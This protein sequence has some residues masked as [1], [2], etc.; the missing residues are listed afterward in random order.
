MLL[1][2]CKKNNCLTS[3]S[4]PSHFIF[5]VTTLPGRQED[6]CT[7]QIKKFPLPLL[8]LSPLCHFLSLP[9]FKPMSFFSPC[10]HFHLPFLFLLSSPPICSHLSA[11]QFPSLCFHLN[12]SLFPLPLFHI[13]HFVPHLL[14]PYCSS[15]T[16]PLPISLLLSFSFSITLLLLPLPFYSTIYHHPSLPL[17]I[18][19][20]ILSFPV[21]FL[22]IFHILAFLTYF[23]LSPIFYP[24]LFQFWGLFE[25]Q[26]TCWPDVPSLENKVCISSLPFFSPF[27][28][29]HPP[30]L[31]SPCLSQI[32]YHYWCPWSFPFLFPDAM[33]GMERQFKERGKAGRGI[34]KVEAENRQW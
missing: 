18:P 30:K 29:F 24:F 22:L 34:G 1:N 13:S 10:W 32:L 16:S 28:I 9:F 25:H 21:S 23:L 7:T 15:P 26:L 2:L 19:F 33:E 8:Y 12:P 3:I 20:C 11:S 6:T 27:Y 4:F 14:L 17:L 31:L 5:G